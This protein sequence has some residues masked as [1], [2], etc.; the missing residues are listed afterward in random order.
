VDKESFEGRPEITTYE[1]EMGSNVVDIPEG[2][3]PVN[4]AP[5]MQDAPPMDT[6]IPDMPDINV[7]I[8]DI[9]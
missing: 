5:P 1:P 7:D 6:D 8:P 2:M 4:D 3:D 9:F